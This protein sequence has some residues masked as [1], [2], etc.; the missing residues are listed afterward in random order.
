MSPIL[1]YIVIDFAS[2][3]R[4]SLGNGLNLMIIDLR[5]SRFSRILGNTYLVLCQKTMMLVPQGRFIYGPF[6]LDNCPI[7]YS[8]RT[9]DPSERTLRCMLF[10]GGTRDGTCE[11]QA[12]PR[13]NKTYG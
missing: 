8:V 2:G 12:R 4:Y 9:I 13:I 11:D 1:V 10:R 3:V 7:E 6:I 5:S